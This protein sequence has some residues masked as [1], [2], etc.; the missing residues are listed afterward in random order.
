MKKQNSLIKI[1]IKN[2]RLT[3]IGNGF[4]KEIEFDEE[5]AIRNIEKALLKRSIIAEEIKIMKHI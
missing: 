3:L 4:I 1:V 2:P 5:Q